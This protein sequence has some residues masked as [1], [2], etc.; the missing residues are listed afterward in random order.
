M[1]EVLRCRIGNWTRARGVSGAR[2]TDQ[3][4]QPQPDLTEIE[5]VTLRDARSKQLFSMIL[6]AI[7]FSLGF[8]TRAQIPDPTPSLTPAPSA[9]PS[10][11]KE[12]L[13]NIL[14]DQK[15]IWTAPFRLKRGDAKWM[16]PF[17]VGT[18]ALITTD[19]LTGDG[20]SKFNRPVHASR[21][22]SYAG[23]TYGAGAVA[24]SFYLIGRAKRDQ[25]A[26]ETGL[27]SAEALIDSLIV[28]S[29]LKAI[30]QRARPMDG[31]E[32]SE[33]FEHGTSFPSGHSIQAWSVATV[34]ANEY[35]SNR[36]VQV[37]AYGIA[38]AVSI[39]R[40]T[41]H[42]HYLSDVLVG[43]LL[44]YGIGR[45]V[46]HTRHRNESES[47]E[48]RPREPGWLAIM[49]QFDRRTHSFGVALKWA[50]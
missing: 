27:L 46:Y 50:F 44:G 15:D 43:S 45:Y 16:L 34:I 22:V 29:G 7:M 20:I 12:F 13:K 42:K 25:R 6:L 37:G 32:R 40:F 39:A 35:Q 31:R 33:F 19:R 48:E 47:A 3:T 18:M 1:F 28:D 24:L 8:L 17:G 5:E 36:A 49:P 9:T 26:R 11:E 4:L 23:S 14:R 41:G 21:V 30:T 10:L 38:S 2:K